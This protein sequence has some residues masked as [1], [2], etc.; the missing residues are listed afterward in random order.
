LVLPDVLPICVFSLGVEVD[1]FT[2]GRGAVTNGDLLTHHQVPLC[3]VG[4]R[5][6]HRRLESFGQVA[7][8][9]PD[10]WS[11]GATPGRTESLF[12]I[13]R[14]Q[15]AA[16]GCTRRR[17]ADA[18]CRCPGKLPEQ[19]SDRYGRD[20]CSVEPGRSW[21]RTT[22]RGRSGSARPGPAGPCRRGRDILRNWSD[23]PF[24][25]RQGP[26]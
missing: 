15:V 13:G 14:Q 10:G 23:R 19:A 25:L 8:G 18:P 6:V 17:P 1:I 2:L 20:G 3:G 11:F 4:F 21:N 26:R 16:T 7:N 9:T 24:D 12:L 22:T 5:P